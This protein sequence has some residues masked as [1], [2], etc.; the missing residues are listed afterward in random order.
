V[1]NLFW[2]AGAKLLTTNTVL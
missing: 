1:T 2:T